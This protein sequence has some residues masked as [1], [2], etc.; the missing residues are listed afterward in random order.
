MIER[1]VVFVFVNFLICCY[2]PFIIARIYNLIPVLGSQSKF[3]LPTMIMT[4]IFIAF[5]LLLLL[6]LFSIKMMLIGIG[7]II[8]VYLFIMWFA[9]AQTDFYKSHRLASPRNQ[10]NMKTR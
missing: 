10:S 8:I 1:K 4:S 6:K 3:M 7:Q 9:F 2:A 5:G